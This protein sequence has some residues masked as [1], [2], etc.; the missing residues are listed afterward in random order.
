MDDIARI[1][2]LEG[3][4]ELEKSKL[5]GQKLVIQTNKSLGFDWTD[6]SY[7]ETW[8]PRLK[9]IHQNYKALEETLVTNRPFD[10]D[11][12]AKDLTQLLFAVY[13][14]FD[15]FGIDGDAALNTLCEQLMK[16][17]DNAAQP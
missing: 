3:L 7:Q 11:Q 14:G 10:K 17:K 2:E 12:I 4:L 13:Q 1:C 5:T 15:C 9:L 16:G 6:S 8:Y